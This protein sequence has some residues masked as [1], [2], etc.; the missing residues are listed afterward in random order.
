MSASRPSVVQT[1]AILPAALLIAACSRQNAPGNG[2]AWGA[3]RAA[4][5]AP[6]AAP[7]TVAAA[8]TPALASAQA[9]PV[10]GADTITVYKDPNCGCCGKWVDNMRANGFTVVTIDQP[11]MAPIKQ[12]YGV[13]NDVASCHT[14]RV[15]GYVVEGHVPASDIRRLLAERPKITGIAAPGMPMGAPGMEMPGMKA[16]TYDVVAFDSAGARSLFAEH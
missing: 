8:A 6:A 7:T 16:D 2:A 13:A 5:A 11:D 9:A 10:P 3:E 12:R 4:A 1:L 15:G 14:A